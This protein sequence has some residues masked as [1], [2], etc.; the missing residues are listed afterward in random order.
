MGRT[1]IAESRHLR[2]GDLR[3]ITALARQNEDLDLMSVT[4]SDNVT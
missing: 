1:L 4:I 3:Y 2:M